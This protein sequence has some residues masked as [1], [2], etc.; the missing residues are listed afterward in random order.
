[1]AVLGFAPKTG[2]LRTAHDLGGLA[3]LQYLAGALAPHR[4][5]HE[6]LYG[7]ILHD[8]EEARWDY[9]DYLEYVR[10]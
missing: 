2:D 4:A 9:A 10:D 5:L 7:Q 8:L 6:Q 3:N 1:M